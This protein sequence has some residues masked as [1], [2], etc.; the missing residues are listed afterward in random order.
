MFLSL[1]S[2]DRLTLDY[3]LKLTDKASY[4]WGL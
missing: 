1:N 3:L 4:I 2:E